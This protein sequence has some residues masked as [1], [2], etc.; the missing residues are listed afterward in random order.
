[1]NDQDESRFD[2]ERFDRILSN[3]QSL[4]SIIET[5]FR[6]LNAENKWAIAYSLGYYYGP[7]IEVHSIKD[8]IAELKRVF[9]YQK[10]TRND[11]LVEAEV[12]I[13]MTRTVREKEQRKFYHAFLKL[14]GTFSLLS[15]NWY[16]TTELVSFW[17]SNPIT[18]SMILELLQNFEKA[19][20]DQKG[21]SY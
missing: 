21:K 3:C 14:Q 7:E 18:E 6:I 19:M 2:G 9:E 17:I 5:C 15:F 16:Q 11:L 1:M 4:F 8:I 12:T 20:R 10:E 13:Q